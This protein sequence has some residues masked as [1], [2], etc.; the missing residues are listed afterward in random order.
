MRVVT[1]QDRDGF[2]VESGRQCEQEHRQTGFV[3]GARDAVEAHQEGGCRNGALAKI[4]EFTTA[5]AARV[6]VAGVP[7]RQ[8][9]A[10][11]ARVNDG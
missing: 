11:A 6:A 9:A 1:V 2:V 5:I 7:Y 8:H 10:A 4:G 3:K